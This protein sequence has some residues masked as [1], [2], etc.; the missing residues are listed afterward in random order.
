L[1]YQQGR[2]YLGWKERGMAAPPTSGSSDAARRLM[3]TNFIGT[4]AVT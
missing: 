2:L 3:D 1:S 4:L